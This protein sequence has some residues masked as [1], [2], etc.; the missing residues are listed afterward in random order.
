[1]IHPGRRDWWCRRNQLRCSLT[2]EISAR[3]DGPVH[4]KLAEVTRRGKEVQIVLVVHRCG[5][6]QVAHVSEQ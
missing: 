1:M 2:R 5:V 3:D 6:E 4:R